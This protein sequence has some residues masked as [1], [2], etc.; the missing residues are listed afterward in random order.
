[1]NF[2]LDG[3]SDLDVNPISYTTLSQANANVVQ[4]LIKIT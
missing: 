3:T 2:G 1:M 4:R